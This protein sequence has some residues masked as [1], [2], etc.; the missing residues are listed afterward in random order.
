M[1]LPAGVRDWLPDELARKRAL[2][3]RLRE[4]FE[5]WRYG[6]VQT[7]GIER[8]DVLEAGLGEMLAD[9][10]LGFADHNGNALVL[11]PETTTPIARLV[12]TRLR[13][14]TLPLRLSYVQSAYRYEE[15]QEGRMREFTQAGLE[16]IGAADVD[17]DAESFF[18]AIEALDAT[19]LVA[20]FDLNHAAIV[21]SVLAGVGYVDAAMREAKRL[22]AARN[23]VDLRRFARAH[24]DDGHVE[25]LAR[26]TLSRG[27][28]DVLASVRRHCASDAGRA[29]VDRLAD[30]LARAR[31]RGLG[32]R[33]CVD[34]SLLRDFA[35]YT[36]LVFEGYVEEVGFA[37]LGGGR[38]DALLGKFGME[39]AAVGWS[40]SV[41]RLLIALERRETR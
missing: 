39:A 11:R 3:A 7:P 40:V 36:G 23:L 30:L 21:E 13:D 22:I 8:L 5:R 17:A 1:R 26:L 10:T 19:G 4:V 28:D 24:R 12:A 35:Y 34:L 25:T 37:L 9:Q 15:P 2:E 20:R 33:V 27:R 18:S 31:T 32:D 29:G 16:L 41:E 14:A 6:E 38:Y